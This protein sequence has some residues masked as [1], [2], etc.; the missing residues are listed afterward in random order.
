MLAATG[1][2]LGR[3]T[4]QR[5]GAREHTADGYLVSR[6]APAHTDPASEAT[7]RRGALSGDRCNSKGASLRAE[8]GLRWRATSA[9]T[10]D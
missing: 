7:R 5:S 2:R 10:W 3:R 4:L 1:T 8:E 6:F 9:G